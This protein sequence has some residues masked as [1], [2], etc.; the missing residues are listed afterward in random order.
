MMLEYLGWFDV[1]EAIT[2]AYEK[3]IAKKIMTYDFERQTKG[4]TK[5]GTSGFASALIE[6]L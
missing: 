2:K 1:A 5:V 6:N 4:A 3:T